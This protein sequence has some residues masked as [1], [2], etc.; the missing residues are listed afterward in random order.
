[1]SL[2]FV[3]IV[4]I[5][6][7]KGRA[8]ASPTTAATPQ[9]TANAAPVSTLTEPEKH[10]LVWLLLQRQE[11]KLSSL[12][13]KHLRTSDHACPGCQAFYYQWGSPA[14]TAR[15]TVQNDHVTAAIDTTGYDYLAKKQGSPIVFDELKS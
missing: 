9:P 3:G 6:C 15:V 10:Y 2:L 5:G 1:M 14:T 12:P 8:P 4:V 13:I 11:A 7:S